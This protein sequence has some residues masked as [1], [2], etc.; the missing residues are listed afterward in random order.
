[1]TEKIKKDFHFSLKTLGRNPVN[2][3]TGP[4]GLPISSSVRGPIASPAEARHASRHGLDRP[5]GMN[6]LRQPDLTQ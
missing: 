6:P 3:W 2:T 4:A 1:M 5:L